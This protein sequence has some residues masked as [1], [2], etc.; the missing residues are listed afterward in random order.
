MSVPLFATTFLDPIFDRLSLPEL[1]AHLLE[2]QAPGETLSLEITQY[3]LM[4]HAALS[5]HIHQAHTHQEILSSRCAVW[6][7]H[8]FQKIEQP[9]RARAAAL[10]ALVR[11]EEMNHEMPLFQIAL[12]EKLLQDLAVVEKEKFP[13]TEERLW[14]EARLSPRLPPA[15]GQSFKQGLFALEILQRMRP[16]LSAPLFYQGEARL[17]QGHVPLARESFARSQNVRTQ[18]LEGKTSRLLDG[19]RYGISTQIQASPER[20]LSLALRA[21]DDRVGDGPSSYGGEAVVGTRSFYLVRGEGKWVGREQRGEIGADFLAKWE[22]DY[23]VGNQSDRSGR[24]EIR[25]KLFRVTGGIVYPLSKEFEITAGANFLDEKSV[26]HARYVGP[27][28]RILW[29]STESRF[30]PRTGGRAKGEWISY[31]P[32]LGSTGRADLLSV[33]GE[34]Y[35]S[36]SPRWRTSHAVCLSSALQSVPYSLWRRSGG[37]CATP[38][39]RP[40]RFK[41]HA[42]YSLW[43]EVDFTLWGP[44]A[45]GG[46]G[47]LGAVS[48][49]LDSLV[50]ESLHPGG[51][52]SL[53]WQLT[54]FKR[55]DIRFEAAVHGG[56]FL[57]TVGGGTTL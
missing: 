14:F 41:D 30:Q 29:D 24:V 57:L 4:E 3:F 12:A 11:A 28:V 23:G 15:Y 44:I 1:Q 10:C 26:G 49:S 16:H 19:E 33:Q 21:Q 27:L 52:L 7:D 13:T 8:H 55:A 43:T 40:G 2:P 37:T 9:R 54:R 51:G 17:L 42:L 50:K 32:A 38:G 39:T 36:I 5:G 56:E 31:F 47:S 25:R 48:S 20:G 35:F 46:F 18:L 22:D 53:Q 34:K 45:L 6:E